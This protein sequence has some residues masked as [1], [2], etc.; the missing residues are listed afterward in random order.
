MVADV[1][2]HHHNSMGFKSAASAEEW[3]A[4]DRRYREKWGL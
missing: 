3:L 2:T 1:D 4:A